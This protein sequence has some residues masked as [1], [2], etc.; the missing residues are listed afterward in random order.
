MCASYG[1]KLSLQNAEAQRQLID[2]IWF[3]AHFPDEVVLKAD[4]NS[5]S[6]YANLEGGRRLSTSIGG[7]LVGLGGDIVIVDDPHNTAQ[8][9][10]E[11][12][13]EN[14]LTGWREIRS[15]RLNDPKR[16]AIVVIMQRLHVEDV[17]GV[18]CEDEHDYETNWVHLM[19]PMRHDPR[20][21]CR[22]FIWEDP[23]QGEELMW[24]ER[25]GETEIRRIEAYLGPYMAS[26]RLQQLPQPQAGGIIK[27]DWWQLWPHPY[28]ETTHGETRDEAGEVVRTLRFPE[29][30]YVLVSLDTA[31]KEREENDWNACTVWGVWLDRGRPR[32][33][34]MEA[35]RVRK[36]LHTE[37]HEPRRDKES[38][39]EFVGRCGLVHQ[40]M[41][42]ASRRKADMVLIED[43]A[44]GSD[45]A[46]EIQLL[47]RDGEYAVELFDP[48]KHGDKV[49]RLNATVPLFANGI[50]F[51][52]DRPWA[53]M[54][55]DEVAQ[56][57]KGKWD[58]LADTVSMALIYLRRNGMVGLSYEADANE[59]RA[60]EFTPGKET[61][62]D[63]YLA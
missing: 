15:T 40:V 4:Q 61:V 1:D 44:R 37:S 45:V 34:L 2:S 59:S 11:V 23:R 60:R 52:P 50:I 57:P 25:F 16:S 7:A 29:V 32:L 5:K 46:N 49:A 28:Y 26:G 62:H 55:I 35:W 53:T 47:M 38:L 22:T 21:H 27:H 54:V 33:I 41:E 12:E 58:D 10:S 17:T 48:G 51:A 31:Y 6:D 20:R 8:V 30:I 42:T 43:K 3:Q 14:S 13:R 24:P 63:H 39:P 19:V 18:I 9:E 36:P 56:V